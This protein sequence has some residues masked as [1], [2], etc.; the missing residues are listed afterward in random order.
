M[1]STAENSTDRQRVIKIS[2][3]AGCL[4]VATLMTAYNLGAFDAAPPAAD[5]AGANQGESGGD[6]RNQQAQAPNQKA[7]GAGG[8]AAPSGPGWRTSSGEL[9]SRTPGR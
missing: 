1:P 6:S 5:P 8:T 3:A 7:G 2:V 4:L 9:E